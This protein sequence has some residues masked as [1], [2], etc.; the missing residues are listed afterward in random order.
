M[1]SNLYYQRQGYVFLRLEMFNE[2][3]K[4]EKGNIFSVCKI[5]NTPIFSTKEK[6]QSK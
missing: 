5:S 4:D 3:D 1:K 6:T 2:L